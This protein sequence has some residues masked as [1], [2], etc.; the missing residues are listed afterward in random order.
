MPYAGLAMRCQEAGA[1]R[2]YPGGGANPSSH[3][4]VSRYQ[5]GA[6]ARARSGAS[7]FFQRE[8]KGFFPYP[9]FYPVSFQRDIPAE[10]DY[11]VSGK[12]VPLSDV[13]VHIIQDDP[14]SGLCVFE[15]V[16]FHVII[17]AEAAVA[18]SVIGLKIKKHADFRGKFFNPFKLKTR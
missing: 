12:T 1:S 3:A 8:R 18:V 9:S 17:G 5:F 16:P 13:A 11:S 6:L 7:V 10:P 2:L 15:D 4:R 14:V